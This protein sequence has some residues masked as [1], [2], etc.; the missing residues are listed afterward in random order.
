MRSIKNMA[1]VDKM[2]KDGYFK[3]ISVL[4]VNYKVEKNEKTRGNFLF[5][6]TKQNCA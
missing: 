1:K 4:K 3:D 6:G 2:D 5:Y